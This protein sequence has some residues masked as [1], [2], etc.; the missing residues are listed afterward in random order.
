MII[1]VNATAAKEGG[2]LTILRQFLSAINLSNKNC[3]YYIFI[4]N[5]ML[6]D[7]IDGIQF[8]QIDTSNGWSRFKWD[9]LGMRRWAVKRN[10]R[11]D[12]IVSF[13]NTGVKFHDVPQIIYYHQMLPLVS[14]KWNPL[15]KKEQTYFFYKNIYPLFVWFFL[16]EKVKIVTQLECI[17]IAFSNKFKVFCNN[18][19]VFRPDITAIDFNEFSAIDF[20]DKRFHLFYPAS[21]HIYKNHI[22]IVLAMRLLSERGYG[23]DIRVHFTCVKDTSIYFVRQINKF[24]IDDMFVF[25]GVIPFEKVIG[26][27]KSVDA[28]L[29]PSYIETFG[30]PLIEAASM[31]LPVLCN[32]LPFTREVLESYSG[33]KFIELHNSL[34]WSQEIELLLQ[35]KKKRFLPLQIKD[36]SEWGNFLELIYNSKI[37]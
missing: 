30:L 24:G 7:D 20:K 28:L 25:E 15:R 35:N 14:Y 21:T 17:K 1:F 37:K 16:S 13:Q 36:Q 33:V 8:V 9:Y 32:D 3:I 4:S 10:L 26:F 19:Y 34:K 23:D 5:I 29:F 18:I 27:Y 6:F 11:P 2:A 12:V 31:G 22:D